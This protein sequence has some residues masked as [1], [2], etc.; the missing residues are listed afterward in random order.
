[1]I[2]ASSVVA[3]L[4]SAAAACR[5]PPAPA[6]TPGLGEIM[7]LTQMRHHAIRFECEQILFV[8]LL[9]MA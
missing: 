9:C 1:M 8:Q 7:T 4:A 5:Q 2:V 6:F 3:L